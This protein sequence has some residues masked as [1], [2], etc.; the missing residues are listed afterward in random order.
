MHL[1][2]VRAVESLG[3]ER[4]GKGSLLVVDGADVVLQHQ[5]L[6][7]GQGAA[8]AGERAGRPVGH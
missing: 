6:A 4:A 2:V 5:A 7:E 3:A 8:G 1:E